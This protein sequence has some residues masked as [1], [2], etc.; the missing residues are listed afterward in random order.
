MVVCMVAASCWRRPTHLYAVEGDKLTALHQDP[1]RLPILGVASYAETIYVRHAKQLTLFQGGRFDARDVQE[2]GKLPPG[3]TTRDV[4]AL[5]S[6]LLVATDKGL[7]VLRGMS[8]SSI[9]GNE[10]LCYED[11]T[12]VTAGFEKQDFWV[13]T[14]R[15]LIRAVPRRISVFRSAAL[16][17]E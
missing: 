13:G 7:A 4:L 8:W 1:S 17:P 14:T 3:A 12:C 16:A 6:R 9:T 15:G 5:G 10:G 2:W 11:T